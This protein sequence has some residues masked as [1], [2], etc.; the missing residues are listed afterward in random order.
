M[1][2]SPQMI[3]LDWEDYFEPLFGSPIIIPKN[4]LLWRGYDTRYNAISERFSYYSSMNIALEYAKKSSRELGGFV[5]T[6]PLK[7]LDI[8]F[9]KQILARIIQLNKSDKYINDFA[10]TIISFGLCSLSHQIRLI[11]IQF[12]NYI[13]TPDGKLIKEGIKKLIEKCTP[14]TVV[15]QEGVR[16]AETT[17]DGTTMAFLQELFADFFDGFISP[18][19]IT[20]FHVEKK[21]QLNPEIIL[22][23]PLKSAIQ[24][25]NIYPSNVI[26][27][28][29]SA[30]IT[31]KHQLVHLDM[32]NN[33]AR[34]TMK[35]YMSGGNGEDYEDTRYNYIKSHHLDEYENKLNSN[36]KKLVKLYTNTIRAGKRWNRKILIT[37]PYAVSP[38]VP[39]TPFTSATL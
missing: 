38:T 32:T 5:T 39:V 14:D 29:I 37:H 4:V 33:E 11:K 9:M 3:E 24:Q 16:I 20:P 30:F 8:R 17:N 23:N 26:I 2:A 15:E 12:G 7:I 25:I 28:P 36:D 13:N 21:G 27:R 31:D 34:I 1:S 19:I 18:R 10:S 22:F 35:M 6:R